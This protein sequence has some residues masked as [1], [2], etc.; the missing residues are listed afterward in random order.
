MID[1]L[2]SKEGEDLVE[3]GRYSLHIYA[4]GIT[5]VQTRLRMKIRYVLYVQI[6]CSGANHTVDTT[7]LL[8]TTRN[9]PALHLINCLH[10]LPIYLT[11]CTI[12]VQCTSRHVATNFLHAEL[13]LEETW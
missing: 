4:S 13:L 7:P 1:S 9:C 6:R 2:S 10:H 8:H 5:Y 11:R 3:S 12:N